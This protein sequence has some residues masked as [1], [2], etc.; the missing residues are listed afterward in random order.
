[1]TTISIDDV[2]IDD[3]IKALCPPLSHAEKQQLERNIKRD[4]F[5]GAVLAWKENDVPLLIDGHHRLELWNK[6]DGGDIKPPVVRQLKFPNRDSACQWII[7]NQLGRRNLPPEKISYLA[8]AK[9]D[10]R[11]EPAAQD[12]SETEQQRQ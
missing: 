11:I 4:G 6:M 2:A 7:T 8:E 5:R 10:Q 3:E 9:E 1:M 12:T